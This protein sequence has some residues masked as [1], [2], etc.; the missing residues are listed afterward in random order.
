M[1][2]RVLLPLLLL[3]M[4]QALHGINIQQFSRSNSLTYESL[5]DSRSQIGHVRNDYK[6]LGTLGYSFVD[7]PL[8]V[9]N[10]ENTLQSASV[11]NKIQTIHV[12]L[13]YYLTPAI[14]VGAVTGFSLFEDTNDDSQQV[15]NDLDLKAKFRLF[16]SDRFTLSVMPAI[17]VPLQA[18]EFDIVDSNNVKFGKQTLLSDNS[19]GFG[20]RV[21]GEYTLKWI[22]II[23]NFGLRFSKDAKFIDR[24]GEVHIDMSKRLFTGIGAYLPV[25]N[26]WGFNLEFAKHWS[27]PFNSNINP[28]E[29]LV[30]TSFGI[31]EN[32]HGFLSVG[33]GNVVGGSGQDGNDIRYAG[34]IK[35]YLN[36]FS[37]SE[38]KR[39]IRI[40]SVLRQESKG[41]QYKLFDHG[42][43][44]TIRFENDRYS[45]DYSDKQSLK[46]FAE[47]LK[48][49][50]DI[51]Q[52][53]DVFGHASAS[54]SDTYNMNLSK[55]RAFEVVSIFMNA[56]VP[57]NLISSSWQGE[58]QLLDKS[59]GKLAAA[60]N[61]RVEVKVSFNNCN[62]NQP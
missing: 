44:G 49:N 35:F 36:K 26:K 60:K 34:G 48:S 58:S 54:A 37:S 57:G 23:A 45:L 13:G 50:I 10:N 25:T 22:Q 1:K 20:A 19:V 8:V 17:T 18:K 61:R 46:S 52:Q 9:K 11:V 31:L 32:I 53:I 56:G 43:M 59:A 14:Q 28:N 51:I 38:L 41:C 33:L 42:N 5:E 24:G 7:E 2:C 55:K 40:D 27:L 12:G 30:G 39:P 15:F 16:R 6:W 29:V 21:L 62:E 47:S 4:T 3:F